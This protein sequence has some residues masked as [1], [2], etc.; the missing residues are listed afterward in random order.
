MNT[1]YDKLQQQHA[2]LNNELHRIPAFFSSSTAGNKISLY[3]KQ[4][5]HLPE[6]IDFAASL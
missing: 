6:T 4:Y 3:T 5:A 2:Y 1:K